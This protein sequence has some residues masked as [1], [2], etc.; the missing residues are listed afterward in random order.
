MKKEVNL[1]WIL[2][3]VVSV[4]ILILSCLEC[5]EGVSYSS[6][7]ISD[8]REPLGKSCNLFQ[9]VSIP[10][11]FSLIVLF[12]ENKI[13][14]IFAVVTLFFQAIVVTLSNKVYKFID[15][16]FSYIGSISYTYKITNV[17]I[18]VSVL[19]WLLFLLALIMTSAKLRTKKHN[20]VNI[21][22]TKFLITLL[23]IILALVSISVLMLRIGIVI[24]I[25]IPFGLLFFIL[26]TTLI[27]FA[28]Y[29]PIRK[30]LKTNNRKYLWIMIIV[31]II[32]LIQIIF[33]DKII[34]I[35]NDLFR[36]LIGPG[37]IPSPLEDYR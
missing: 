10:T 34:E 30:T 1:F 7:P 16:L 32:F 23:S 2:A 22:T 12:F 21:K 17:G 3:V 9:L 35:W 27:F 19:C 31:M 28:Y 25:S 20:K 15:D 33:K 37:S 6:L 14:N 5:V 4:T 11:V 18:I 36:T 29:Y 8:T 26:T 13:L 24:E